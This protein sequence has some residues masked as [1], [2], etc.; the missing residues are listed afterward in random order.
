MKN[1]NWVRDL[2]ND[3]AFWRRLDERL[4]AREKEHAERMRQLWDAWTS[5]DKARTDTGMTM[6]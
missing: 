5:S 3:E 6:K 2:A 1:P 4:A